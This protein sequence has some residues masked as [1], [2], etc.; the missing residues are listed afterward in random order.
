LSAAANELVIAIIDDEASVRE[1]AESLLRS[2]GYRTQCFAS[3]E[4]FLQSAGL[5]S[6]GCLVLDMK[7]PGMSGLQLQQQV[8]RLHPD[9]PVIFITASD[10]PNGILRKQALQS[11]ALA[12]LRKPFLEQELLSAIQS[13]VGA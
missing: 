13:I 8:R 1:A 4:D 9:L 11:G 10:D 3:A 7:L 2:A 5:R 12:F 6:A